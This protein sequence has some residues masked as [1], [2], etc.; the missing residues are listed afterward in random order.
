[1]R[2][3]IAISRLDAK[4]AAPLASLFLDAPTWHA[5]L[6][7][8]RK[9]R[10][11]PGTL[12]STSIE[13]DD[14]GR[15]LLDP[16]MRFAYFV[17]EARADEGLVAAEPEAPDEGDRS[18]LEPPEPASAALT[19]RMAAVPDA[20]PS[21]EAREVTK[22]SL[23]SPLRVSERV[24]A[25]VTI[26]EAPPRPVP[27]PPPSTRDLPPFREL[28]RRDEAPGGDSGI[29]YREIAYA[30]LPGTTESV[31]EEVLRDRL[32][33]VVRELGDDPRGKFVNLAVFDHVFEGKPKRRPVATLTY[34]D[35]KGSE[36]LIRFPLLEATASGRPSAP[37]LPG[38]MLQPR[39]AVAHVLGVGPHAPSPTT[40]AGLD[41]GAEPA[42]ATP[43]PALTIR[44]V[45][46]EPPSIDPPTVARA[47][48]EVAEARAKVEAEEKAR[49]DEEKARD[50]EERAR[51]EAEAKAREE[52]DAKAKAEAQ[53]KAREEAEAKAREEA[54]A[55][56]KAEA[57]AKARE[58]AEAKAREEA[59]AKAKAE[60]QAKAREEADAKAREEADAKAREEAAAKAREEAAAKAR[61]EAEAKAREEAAAKAREEAEA[62]AKADAQA[63]AREEA[64]AKARA[65]AEA[66]AAADAASDDVD[67]DLDIPVELPAEEPKVAAPRLEIVAEAAAKE[68]VKQ[69]AAA[70]KP[71]QKA[72][73]QAA[74]APSKKNSVPPPSNRRG[75][76]EAAPASRRRIRLSGEDLL[77]ELF[78]AF[79]F[80][81]HMPDCLEGAELLLQVA[82][83]KLP[84]EAMFVSLFDLNRREFLLVRHY[85]GSK[86]AL[87]QRTPEA[88]RLARAA[89]RRQSAVVIAEASK[90]DR[91]DLARYAT[92]GVVPKSLVAA[93][94]AMGGRYLG[95]LE[96]VNPID[97][98]PFT[99]GDGNAISYMAEQ[100]AEL[101]AMR[102]VIIHPDVVR[103]SAEARR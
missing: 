50:A 29:V 66:K 91:V 30:V 60:A 22:P 44:G 17:R 74:E 48:A 32:A 92:L 70:D 21:S 34:K 16:S 33:L 101:L 76:D 24:S 78:E 89:M 63:K 67:V 31:A 11:E 94:V 102:G 81:S 35:W 37:S 36:P 61:E 39:G 64:E 51:K 71:A 57:Q 10:G 93:P 86:A 38:G 88:E 69:A 3:S 7:A 97:G 28:S 2:W 6:V 68:P 46:V 103:E 52:A 98:R 18:A 8:A 43:I 47:S 42:R 13:V 95:L 54:E 19:Q 26:A 27:T 40:V 49:Q 4:E 87:L 53:A 12:T 23:P 62:K 15:H 100:Y 58:E 77:A 9:S 65:E 79:S 75:G 99:E 55:K 84:C 96:L 45:D 25:A 41:F 56:A 72:V 5:A 14:E 82:E 1:M 59:E 73:K 85:G 90:D 80:L 20:A 83:E